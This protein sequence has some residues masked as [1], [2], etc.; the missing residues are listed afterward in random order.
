MVSNRDIGFVHAGQD[1]A[2]QG[3]YLQFHPLRAAPRPRCSACRRTRSRA[4]SRQD[5]NGDAGAGTETS[6]SEPKGQELVYSARISL[7]RTQMQVEDN[8]V[9]LFARHGGH[10]GDQ[11]RLAPVI[12]ICCRR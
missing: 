2:D 8:L 6:S 10:G 11:D 3:R 12:T 4:T 9:N 7:D 1:A 5:K